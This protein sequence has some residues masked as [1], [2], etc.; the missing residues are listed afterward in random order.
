MP[1]ASLSRCGGNNRASK[2]SSK[3]GD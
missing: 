2:K 3:C 1:M